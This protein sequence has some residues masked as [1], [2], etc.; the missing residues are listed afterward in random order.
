MWDVVE[1]FI[2]HSASIDWEPSVR[3]WEET[4]HKVFCLADISVT[5]IM[6]K[7]C[8]FIYSTHISQPPLDLCKA[9]TL[10]ELGCG[11]AGVPVRGVECPL[12]CRGFLIPW[13]NSCLLGAWVK[14]HHRG[15]IR[16]FLPVFLL[17]A[18]IGATHYMVG[19]GRLCGSYLSWQVA[20][21]AE[22]PAVAVEGK[23]AEREILPARWGLGQALGRD[24]CR[25]L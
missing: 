6:K 13:V 7:S 16:N 18:T 17:P 14:G 9:L 22:R 2:H 24:T 21:S 19:R 15:I 1:L 23:G 8:Q 3:F 4:R 10:H 5:H 12:K 11:A 20:M 25:S